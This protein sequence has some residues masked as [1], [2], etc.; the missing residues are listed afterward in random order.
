MCAFG[1]VYF[2]P[3]SPRGER[4]DDIDDDRSHGISIHA[5][6]VGSD[7]MGRQLTSM[8]S[9]QSTLP[10]WGATWRHCHYQRHDE[11][12]STLPAWGAT[13]I[14]YHTCKKIDFNPRSPR[15]E[16]HGQTTSVQWQLYFNPRSPRGER[17]FRAACN[18]SPSAFQST[19]PAWGATTDE[20]KSLTTNRYFNPRSPRG[21]RL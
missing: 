7:S 3:R 6:R 18:G 5:P 12:Q 16:R 11:F 10:A 13:Q 8:T 2:N 1:R 20:K 15:G 4:R 19:L 21:E 9:F 17:L 14:C